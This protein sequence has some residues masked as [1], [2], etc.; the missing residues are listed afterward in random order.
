MNGN[1]PG[2]RRFLAQLGLGVLSLPHKGASHQRQAKSDVF[3]TNGFKV[4]EVTPNTAILWT[5]L[6]GR[7]KP[8]PILHSRREEIFRHPL[9]FDE[10]QP[11]DVMDGAVPGAAGEVRFVVEGHRQRIA[12]SWIPAL[13]ENDYTAHFRLADLR[14][15]TTYVTRVEGRADGQR[16]FVVA[17]GSFKTLPPEDKAVSANLVTSTC[18]YF[19]SF[20]DPV[21]GFRTY[22]SMGRLKPDLYIHTG[23][24]VYYDKPGPLATTLEKARHKWH[25]MDGWPALR[26]FY[27][28]VP[29]YM[30][31]DDHDLLFNDAY[32]EMPPYG[33]L[34]YQDGLRLWYQNVPLSGKPY[35]TLRYGRDLQIWIVEGREFR[36]PNHAQDEPGKSIWGEEQKQW[37]M[38]TVE[39]SEAS[40]KILFS[41]TPVVGPDR[42]R[43][44][45]NHANTGYATEGVWLRQYL[46]RH[47][48]MFV[49][50][51]DRHWQY[52]SRDPGTG[53]ME[54][55]SG[56][57]SDFH[58]QGWDPNDKRPEHRFLRVK[59]GFLNITLTYDSNRPILTFLHRDV[60]GN[61]VHQER[62]S[63]ANHRQS[64][65]R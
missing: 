51:G 32:P 38:E 63:G 8:N 11:V 5:R 15:A 61:V 31:K 50:N 57:V 18:Q 3:F 36:T 22:D 4:M 28:H 49:V 53:V 13:A 46:S 43:K 44:N 34:T 45:D 56:P 59:G 54:F 55:G 29:V 17:E 62:F 60:D 1:P 7:E 6:C 47:K 14:P 19:W 35:R 27:A 40:F 9:N 21:R 12:S 20:D 2:R 42:G 52:V 30:I 10:T 39:A 16:A 58:A 65:R 23:D 26:E 48:N 33:E 24:Y 41:P 25:A 37:F 64:K